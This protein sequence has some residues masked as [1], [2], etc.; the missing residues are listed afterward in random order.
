MPQQWIEMKQSGYNWILAHIEEN[1]Q[2]NEQDNNKVYI[3]GKTNH[4]NE[5]IIKNE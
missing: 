1:N 2:Q 5:Q 3:N 4:Q